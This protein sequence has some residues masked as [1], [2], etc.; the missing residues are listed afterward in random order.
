M[1]KK[2][3][4]FQNNTVMVTDMM[5]RKDKLSTKLLEYFEKNFDVKLHNVKERYLKYKNNCTTQ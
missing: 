5:E 2:E 1:G 4:K 3:R